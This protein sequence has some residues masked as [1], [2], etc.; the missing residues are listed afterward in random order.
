MNQ[1]IQFKDVMDF[2]KKYI[3]LILSSALLGGAIAFAVSS[4]LISKQYQSNVQILVNQKPADQDTVQINEIQTNVSMINTYVDILFGD[5]VLSDVSEKMDEAYSMDELRYALTYAHNTNSQ[6]FTITSM[7]GN[8]EDAQDVLTH[9]VASFDTA[10][11]DIYQVPEE[12]NYVNVIS[13][14]TYNP[15]PTSP[16]VPI[17]TLIGL[18]FGAMIGLALSLIREISDN[19]ITSHADMERTGMVQLGTI[20]EISRRDLKDT[21]MNNRTVVKEREA[22]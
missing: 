7:L 8:P 6:A 17:I 5:R 11:R 18:L 10:I 1:L 19:K 22:H 15:Q 21:R 3:L 2:L 9:L 14:P 20:R 13:Q 4:T 12:E 16:N